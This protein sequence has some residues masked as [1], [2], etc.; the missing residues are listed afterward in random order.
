FRHEKVF[1]TEE[2]GL[3]NCEYSNTHVDC[4]CFKQLITNGGRPGGPYRPDGRKYG[5]ATCASRQRPVTPYPT[6][7][8]PWEIPFPGTSCQAT[9]AL[10]WSFVAIGFLKSRGECQGWGVTVS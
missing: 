9:I 6:G 8:I 1:A 5:S 10:G 4:F 3:K 7:R 2:K